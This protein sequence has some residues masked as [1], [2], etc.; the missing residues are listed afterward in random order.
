MRT[1]AFLCLLGNLILSSSALYAQF[2]RDDW[3]RADEGTL[4][5]SSSAFPELP[6]NVRQEL[7]SRGC[8]IPQSYSAGA[9]KVNVISGK[10]ISPTARDWAVLCS[11]QR[12]SAILVFH[13]DQWKE[14]EEIAEQPDL[15]YLQ[16]VS[17][18]GQIGYSRELGVAEPS[19]IR[20]HFMSRAHTARNIEHDGIEDT[21]VEK[22]SVVWY[23]SGAKWIK[24]SGA[25]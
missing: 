5:L 15:Q 16:A 24:L 20:K 7:E 25:D 3:R 6:R 21:F 10:F 22:G 19:V 8:S 13:G 18:K 9:K 17:G 23:W 2:T 1:A 14:V 11:R 12:R 4:R